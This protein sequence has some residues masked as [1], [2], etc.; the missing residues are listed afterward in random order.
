[1][2]DAGNP[3]THAAICANAHRGGTAPEPAERLRTLLESASSVVLDV[4]GID[5]TERPGPP[6]LVDCTVLPDGAI[7]VLTGKTS[8]LHRIATLARDERLTGELDA[9]DVAP[10][11]MPHRIRGRASVQGRLTVLTGAVRT[12]IETLFPH[13]PADGHVLLRLEPGH[14]AVEDLW[15]SACC[16]DPAAFAAAEPDPVARE[17][18]GLLQHLDAAHADQLHRLALRAARGR[19]VPEPYAVRP[20]ALDRFG[21]RVRLFAPDGRVLDARFDFARPLR[22]PE[23]LPEAMHRL[24][25]HVPAG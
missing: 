17:E 12:G 8:P 24:F 9:V 3:R 11:A 16:V 1:M 21:L 23:E 15:G 22:S 5:L 18:A 2:S 6:P 7:A 14:L 10:V 20:V 13:R 19:G 25:A 4:P